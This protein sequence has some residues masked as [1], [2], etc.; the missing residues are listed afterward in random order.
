[1]Y[2]EQPIIQRI[3]RA[4]AFA[5]AAHTGIG[6][7]RK[8]T[9]EPYYAHCKAVA[10]IVRSVENH[11][12]EMIITAYLHDVV[13][14]THLEL[15]DL[16]QFFGEGITK[17]VAFLTETSK[18]ERPDLNRAQRKTLDAYRLVQ[19]SWEVQTVKYADII[20]NLSTIYRDD[21]AFAE[22]YGKEKMNTL[23]IARYGDPKIRH[24]ALKRIEE[25]RG[26]L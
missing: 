24:Y 23:M 16:Y 8:Y 26:L 25:K 9:G 1:M 18:E 7:K 3:D 11:T 6:Q 21:P 10:D 15:D 17:N 5:Y 12:T 22:V 19:A 2:N 14:D 4:K 20:H 13:E